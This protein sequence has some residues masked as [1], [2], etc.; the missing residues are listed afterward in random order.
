[1]LN[2]YDEAETLNSLYEGIGEEINTVAN[3]EDMNNFLAAVEEVR[4]SAEFLMRS[5]EAV[6][7]RARKEIG[8]K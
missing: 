4:N 2:F 5:A 6:I 3:A 8:P 1:M 7:R